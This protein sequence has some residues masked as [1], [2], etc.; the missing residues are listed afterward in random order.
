[1]AWICDAKLY[2]AR[3]TGAEQSEA[4]LDRIRQRGMRG[5]GIEWDGKWENTGRVPGQ[6]R[7]RQYSMA[8]KRSETGGDALLVVHQSGRSC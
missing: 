2:R 6:R 5:D 8:R 7:A 1:M 4:E 3:R